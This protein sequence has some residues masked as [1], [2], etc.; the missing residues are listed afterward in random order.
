[1]AK[2]K[3]AIC[4]PVIQALAEQGEPLRELAK[5]LAIPVG[6]VL[7]RSSREKWRIG[8]RQRRGR[9]PERS[10][11]ERAAINET[12]QAGRD[13]F[14]Q[15]G[16]LSRANLAQA[17]V[18]ASAFLAAMKGEEILENSQNFKNVTGAL[19]RDIFGWQAENGRN[20]RKIDIRMVD[21]RALPAR[22]AETA[23]EPVELGEDSEGS[24]SS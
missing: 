20:E 2:G 18:A 1:M 6:T 4:W 16:Q 24:N 21:L 7:A 5:R 3:K 15:S 22:E 14:A 17:A 23:S 10:E 11:A 13:Y 12:L 19:S 9:K 8:R